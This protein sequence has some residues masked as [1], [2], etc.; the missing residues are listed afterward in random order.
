LRGAAER[1]TVFPVFEVPGFEHVTD[2]PEKPVIADLL[3]QYP[4]KDFVVN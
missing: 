4:E 1:V 3:R 2:Q